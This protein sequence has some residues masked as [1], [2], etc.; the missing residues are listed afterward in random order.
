MSAYGHQMERE[1]SAQSLSSRGGSEMGSRYTVETG[2]YMSS[3]AA[4]VFIGGLVTVGVSLMTL[5]I[6]LAVMLQSCQSKN[7]GMVELRSS[8]DLHDYCKIL[9]LHLEL[10]HLDSDTLPTICQEH[11]A[12]YF[13]D[14]HYTKEL[15]ITL[16]LIENYFSSIRPGG[17][18]VV[19][20]DAD[21]L[22]A[23]ELFY[24]NQ[25]QK[26]FDQYACADCNKDA[27]FPK[28]MLVHELYMKLRAGG[29]PLILLSRKPERQRNAI[30]KHLLSIG[31]GDWSSLIMRTDE[32][33]E[34]D[35]QEYIWRR[36]SIIQRQGLRIV[37]TIS[38]QL[39]FLTGPSAGSRNF[40]LPKVM[41]GQKL[42]YHIENSNLKEE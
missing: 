14:G 1:Y 33:M 3:F 2:I 40:K 25:L 29:W 18:D 4:T 19:L 24:V 27:K 37:A 39:D 35:R 31:C 20:M 42:E 15:N 9:A 16:M 36:R 13:R 23:S 17:Q 5:L 7:A 22:F 10:N 34:M 28:Q 21:D 26:R 41:Y 11:T 6:A 32:E 12:Q 30:V 8:A 38:S